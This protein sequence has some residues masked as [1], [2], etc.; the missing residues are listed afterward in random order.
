MIEYLE[1]N[2]S[3]E[4]G[5]L[6]IAWVPE[7]LSDRDMNGWWLAVGNGTHRFFSGLIG[8]RRNR[9]HVF[10]KDPPGGIDGAL[11]ASGQPELV[12]HGTVD[13]ITIGDQIIL[14]RMLKRADKLSVP[15][16]KHQGV[17]LGPFKVKP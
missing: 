2:R 4:Y 1:D 14:D 8:L 3:S 5:W 9:R 15:D 12:T 11:H 10:T 7:E 6:F 17:V 16:L 13:G